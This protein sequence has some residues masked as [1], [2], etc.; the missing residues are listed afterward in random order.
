MF[1]SHFHFYDTFMFKFHKG[2]KLGIVCI[3]IYIASGNTQLHYS[4]S[5]K[6]QPLNLMCSILDMINL[7]YFYLYYQTRFPIRQNFFLIIK[8]NFD[9][10]SINICIDH[11]LYIFIHKRSQCNIHQFDSLIATRK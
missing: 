4:F 2:Y 5:N 11:K 1:F 6:F 9:I 3:F 7:I 10:L 8:N